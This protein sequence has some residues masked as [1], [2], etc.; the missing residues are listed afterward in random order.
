VGSVSVSE[1]VVTNNMLKSNIEVE[2]IIFNLNP[3]TCIYYDNQ[4]PGL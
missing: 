3:R 4:I 2:M 1:F